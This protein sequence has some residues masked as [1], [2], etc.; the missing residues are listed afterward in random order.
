MAEHLKS[1]WDNMPGKRVEMLQFFFDL[2]CDDP[3]FMEVRL[4]LGPSIGS[5]LDLV[6]T[7]DPAS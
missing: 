5:I 3:A 2:P 6:R 7:E 4:E 1:L